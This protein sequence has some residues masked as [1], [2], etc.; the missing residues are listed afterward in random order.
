[1]GRPSWDET[2]MALVDV[3]AAR[4]TC[5]RLSVGAVVVRERQ[6]LASG[7]N[8]APRGL[9]HCLDEG[10]LVDDA[11]HCLRAVHAEANAIL[12][13]ARLGISLEGSTLYTSFHPC[14]RCSLLI[15]QVGIVEVVYR[16]GSYP[17]SDKTGVLAAAGVRLRTVG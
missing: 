4:A 7:Y 10:C 1:M 15:A 12:Q 3:W 17:R 8:G 16:E 5:P 13:A 14:T 9:D 11:N 2:F 6:V